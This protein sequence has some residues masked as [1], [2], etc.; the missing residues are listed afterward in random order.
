MSV[1]MN[2]PIRL[3]SEV[4]A[5]ASPVARRLWSIG[6]DGSDLRRLVADIDWADLR[7]RI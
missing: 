2:D 6:V 7:P 4:P 3:V 1:A 5:G